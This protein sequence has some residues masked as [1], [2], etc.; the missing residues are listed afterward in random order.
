MKL[1]VIPGRRDHVEQQ[2]VAT[3][4]KTEATAEELKLKQALFARLEQRVILHA[5]DDSI[6]KPRIEP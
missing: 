3:L 2:L 6:E 4:F 1:T 5:V